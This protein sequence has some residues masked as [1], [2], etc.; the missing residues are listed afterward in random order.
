[1]VSVKIALFDIYPEKT[2]ELSNPKWAFTEEALG[3]DGGNVVRLQG[4]KV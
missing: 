4:S 3:W 2:A 1:M